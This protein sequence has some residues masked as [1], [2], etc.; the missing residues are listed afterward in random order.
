MSLKALTLYVAAVASLFLLINFTLIFVVSMSVV[1]MVTGFSMLV[2]KLWV[3]HQRIG[4]AESNLVYFLAE[5]QGSNASRQSKRQERFEDFALEAKAVIAATGA[6]TAQV[7]RGERLG[8]LVVGETEV[9]T[10]GI[11]RAG[12]WMRELNQ[13]DRKKGS[14]R[15]AN[16]RNNA[17]LLLLLHEADPGSALNLIDMLVEQSEA[18]G[19]SLPVID[20]NLLWLSNQRCIW[21]WLAI[22]VFRHPSKRLSYV[23]R[24]EDGVDHLFE[25]EEA[26]RYLARWGLNQ[27]ARVSRIPPVR[28]D[29]RNH[30]PVGSLRP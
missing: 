25:G 13:S 17:Q 18:E 5:R 26:L 10:A 12:E 14:T 6:R 19:K 15:T 22:K 11:S 28:P 9:D 29:A 20:R 23:L 8:V 30:G 1:L 27:Q 21:I 16:V 7:G 4:G 2:Y 3:I 24:A